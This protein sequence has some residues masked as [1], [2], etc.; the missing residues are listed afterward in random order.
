MV[1]AEPRW[2]KHLGSPPPTAPQPRHIQKTDPHHG[3]ST[4][5]IRKL[6]MDTCWAA[7]SHR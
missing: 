2:E 3:I 7:L 4:T 5:P 6:L 1:K